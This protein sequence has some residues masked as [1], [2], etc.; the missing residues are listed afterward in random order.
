M[1]MRHHAVAAFAQVE[2]E[3]LPDQPLE[4]RFVLAA[5]LPR[6]ASGFCESFI[7]NVLVGRFQNVLLGR[8]VI[9][10]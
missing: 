8:E 1:E 6:D 7:Y 10:S 3:H 5:V 4:R 9:G 2:I